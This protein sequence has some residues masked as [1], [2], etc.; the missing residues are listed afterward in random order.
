M[1]FK[2]QANAGNILQTLLRT[3]PS[4]AFPLCNMLQDVRQRNRV[5]KAC[6]VDIALAFFLALRVY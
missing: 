6:C 2:A 1:A 3:D 5:V 4:N